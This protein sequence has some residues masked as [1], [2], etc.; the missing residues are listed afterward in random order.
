MR[1]IAAIV[2]V[3][4]ALVCVASF[5]QAGMVTMSAQDCFG[6]GCVQQIT[7]PQPD[8]AP[9][10]AATAVSVA[11]EEPVAQTEPMPR[12]ST[13]VAPRH[14]SLSPLAPRSPPAA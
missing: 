5:A 13:L 1:A 7:R 4:T 9:P 14:R 3:V 10:S 8:Q 2:L 12:A 11:I 6:P